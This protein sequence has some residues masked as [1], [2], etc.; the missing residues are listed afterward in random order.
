MQGSISNNPVRKNQLVCKVLINLV[1]G[2][3]GLIG[4][5][6]YKSAERVAKRA[7]SLRGGR[8]LFRLPTQVPKEIQG[9]KVYLS[10]LPPL[11]PVLFPRLKPERG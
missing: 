1:L 2:R 5:V 6:I 3:S 9:E 7:A 4:T 10:T 11:P 8:F